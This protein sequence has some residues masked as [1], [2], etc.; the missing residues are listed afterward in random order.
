MS[1]NKYMLTKTIPK[2][3][4]FLRIK[5]L[6]DVAGGYSTPVVTFTGGDADLYDDSSNYRLLYKKR[7]M[8]EWKT[9]PS[10]I[11]IK[12]PGEG[13]YVDIKKAS[14]TSHNINAGYST[15]GCFHIR[16]G[17]FWSEV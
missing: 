16:L 14:T 15:Y 4:P 17:G 6:G 11:E 13:N 8:D 9:L 5:N 12:I 1:L 10:G 3:G 2:N 7:D